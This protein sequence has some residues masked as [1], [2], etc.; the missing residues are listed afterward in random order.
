MVILKQ[1][2]YELGRA[3]TNDLCFRDVAGLSRKHMVFE[4]DGTTWVVR[5]LGSTNGTF[6]NGTQ[7]SGTHVL[8]PK[9]RVTAGEL[10]VVFSE[11]GA[12]ANQ[13]V[14]FIEKAAT[15]T[16]E[17]SMTG[18]FDALEEESKSAVGAHVEAL[19]RAGRELAGHM[20]LDKLFDLIL[21]L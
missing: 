16:E 5:D 6:V 17:T 18:S 15:T 4:R 3:D 19:I 1:D 13:T 12:A 14:V 8:K 21:D 11:G 7:L 20:P 10:S 2:R 9:D